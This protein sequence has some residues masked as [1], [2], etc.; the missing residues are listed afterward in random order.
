M[1]GTDTLKAYRCVIRAMVRSDRKSRIAQRMEQ[2]RKDIAMLTYKRMNVVRA[3]NAAI[4]SM[5]KSKLFKELQMLN[6]QV[7]LLKNEQIERDKRLHFVGDTCILREKLLK[8]SQ[9][10]RPRLLQHFKDIAS[11]LENQREY[12]ELIERYN[13]G[14]KLSQSETVKRTASRVGLEVPF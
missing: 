11:F 3:Q 2:R 13:G 4:D 10:E 8:G 6:R 5:Q 1:I 12:D 7:D 9:D 14:S